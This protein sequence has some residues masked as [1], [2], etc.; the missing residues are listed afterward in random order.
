MIHRLNEDPG[1]LVFEAAQV[2]DLGGDCAV[3]DFAYSVRV[4]AKGADRR[5]AH[6]RRTRLRSGKILDLCNAFMVEC[7]IYD[8]SDKGVRVRL[9]ADIPAQPV[10]RL[11]E[12]DPER[13]RDARVVWWKDFELGLCFVRRAGARRISRTQLT[14]LRGRYYAIDG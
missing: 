1:G 4:V 11:Y 14:C 5:S 3:A 10:I 13:L 8:R 12:D 7:Q 9:L 2:V 6:R